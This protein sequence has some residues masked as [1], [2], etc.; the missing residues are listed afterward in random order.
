MGVD[1]SLKLA[2]VIQRWFQHKQLKGKNI[3]VN[4]RILEWGV[5]GWEGGL[6][7]LPH[8]TKKQAKE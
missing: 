8:S 3:L 2:N 7:N 4:H 5:G 1:T 6:E